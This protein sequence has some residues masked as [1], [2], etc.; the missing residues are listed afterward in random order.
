MGKTISV[1]MD[2]RTFGAWRVLETAFAGEPGMLPVMVRG[3]AGAWTESGRAVRRA[4][5]ALELESLSVAPFTRLSLTA[6]GARLTAEDDR[7]FACHDPALRATGR[8]SKSLLTTAGTV[9]FRVRRYRDADGDARYPLYEAT[10]V[11]AP[12]EK[13]SRGLSAFAA[14]M[15]CEMSYR[16]ACEHVALYSREPVGP[17]AL[18]AMLGTQSRGLERHAEEASLRRLEGAPSRGAAAD[19]L[20]MEA[21]GVF[22]HVQR[23]PEQK[24][25]GAPGSVQ[26]RCARA[27]TGK[28]DDGGGRVEC[29]DALCYAA[30]EPMGVFT[31]RLAGLIDE[32]WDLSTVKASFWSTDGERAYR[33]AADA[34]MA[35][36]RPVTDLWHVDDAINRWAPKG[37]RPALRRAVAAGDPGRALRLLQ[38]ALSIGAAT[39]P[40]SPGRDRMLA[41]MAQLYGY[42][43]S[44]GEGLRG[45]SMGSQEGCNAH[46]L[47]S[48]LKHIGGAWSPDGA[49]AIAR[50]RSWK[51]SHHWD[52]LRPVP[53]GPGGKGPAGHTDLEHTRAYQAKPPLTGAQAK[54]M[55]DGHGRQARRG[56]IAASGNRRPAIRR[57]G[58]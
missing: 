10:G 12:R 34:V 5:D 49:D 17:A 24:K 35:D 1:F 13:V 32:R 20:F 57:L 27:Y 26:I 25:A 16:A 39:I 36:A 41:D 6:L 23:T 19:T 11:C 15:G 58:R 37:L 31:D 51:A 38:D 30:V 40:A 53:V 44:V 52:T 4:T 21:D 50:C 33:N 3:L 7:L 18:K 2:E 43:A 8:S 29:G 48:R 42:V 28:K 46:V 47:G 45:V 55:H 56:H 14:S 22:A 9:T 54:R